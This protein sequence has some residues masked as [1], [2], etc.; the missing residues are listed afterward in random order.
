MIKLNMAK[1]ITKFNLV[2]T[3][4]WLVDPKLIYHF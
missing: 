3:Q 4:L 1:L 2:V